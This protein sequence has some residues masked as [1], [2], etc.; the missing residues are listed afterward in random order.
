MIFLGANQIGL[1]MGNEVVYMSDWL[2][3]DDLIAKGL[4]RE[5]Y[6]PSDYNAYDLRITAKG[7]AQAAKEASQP[8]VPFGAN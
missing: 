7:L 1:G 5:Q 6:I 4:L 2:E 8:F 3:V